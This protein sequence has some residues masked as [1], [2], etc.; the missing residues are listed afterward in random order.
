MIYSFFEGGGRREVVQVNKTLMVV[1]IDYRSTVS[2]NEL[3]CDSDAQKVDSTRLSIC[4]RR[5]ISAR[6]I[7]AI[8]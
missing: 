1:N 7:V 6:A 2:I 5:R 4:F 3:W 8:R